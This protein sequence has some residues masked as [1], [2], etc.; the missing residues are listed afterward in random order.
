M[1]NPVLPEEVRQAIYEFGAAKTD[2]GNIQSVSTADFAEQMRAELDAA[3]LAYG[4]QRYRD[5][6]ESATTCISCGKS[7]VHLKCEGFC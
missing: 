5:G 2:Y 6:V 7:G 3:I 1:T 4:E